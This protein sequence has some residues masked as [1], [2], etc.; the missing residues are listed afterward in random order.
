MSMLG[1]QPFIRAN[2]VCRIFRKQMVITAQSSCIKT[3]GLFDSCSLAVGSLGLLPV[4][5][6]ASRK[7]LAR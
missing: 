3:N 2:S 5:C 6:F 1:M 7:A 4:M